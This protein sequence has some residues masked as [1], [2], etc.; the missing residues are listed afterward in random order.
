MTI[1]SYH[2]AVELASLDSDTVEPSMTEPLDATGFAD[3]VFPRTDQV[4]AA[5]DAGAGRR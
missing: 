4:A 1:W 3:R 2:C 5:L